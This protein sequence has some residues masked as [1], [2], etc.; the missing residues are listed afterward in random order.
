MPKYQVTIE[1]KRIE[2]VDVEAD[3]QREARDRAIILLGEGA[4]DD[5]LSLPP[6]LG[7]KM[8]VLKMVKKGK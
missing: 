5:D 8:K 3:N 7:F 4:L 6:Y 2:K 1:Q